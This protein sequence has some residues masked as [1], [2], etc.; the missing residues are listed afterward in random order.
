M[1]YL[2]K[3]LSVTTVLMLTLIL[4]VS[5]LPGLVF[6]VGADGHIGLELEHAAGACPDTHEEHGNTGSQSQSDKDDPCC[7][8]C[9]DMPF[10]ADSNVQT[11]SKA[12]YTLRTAKSISKV[13]ESLKTAHLY[14][15]K[16]LS[17]ASFLPRKDP[18]LES[19]G[20]CAL[21]TIILRI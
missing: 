2:G 15:P 9:V 14:S 19:P 13:F 16:G 21:R 6:C 3:A 12:A 10:S 11:A 4:I 5:G 7:P 17:L 1:S 8:P 20:L 18:S